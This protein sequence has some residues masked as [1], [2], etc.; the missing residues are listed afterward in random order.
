MTAARS[1]ASA[2]LLLDG[3]VLVVGGVDD[4][5]QGEPLASAELYAL[6]E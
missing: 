4:R 3:R 6:G 2:T 5:G 1:G